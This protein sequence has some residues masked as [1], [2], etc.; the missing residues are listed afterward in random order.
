MALT[1]KGIGTIL[2]DREDTTIGSSIKDAQILGTPYIVVL[3]DKVKPGEI[4]IECTRT[5][6]KIVVQKQR[7]LDVVNK[8]EI[9]GKIKEISREA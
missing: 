2:D 1:S 5:G 8:E 3:G 6:K 7:I 9:K 4:E